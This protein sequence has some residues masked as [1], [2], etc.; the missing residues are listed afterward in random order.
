MEVLRGFFRQVSDLS[1]EN[2]DLKSLL[3]FIGPDDGAEACLPE[4]CASPASNLWTDTDGSLLGA[5]GQVSNA[6]CCS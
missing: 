6:P 1:Q 5:V 2:V 4:N 3:K